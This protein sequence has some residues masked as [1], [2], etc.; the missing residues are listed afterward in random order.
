MTS[1]EKSSFSAEAIIVLSLFY[2]FMHIHEDIIITN[3]CTSVGVFL[4]PTLAA[5]SCVHLFVC[6]CAAVMLTVFLVHQD[7]KRVHLIVLECQP[8][9]L[10]CVFICEFSVHEA[11]RR[12]QIQTFHI[13][14]WVWHF[15][16]NSFN[17]IL[18]MLVCL[19]FNAYIF[20]AVSKNWSSIKMHY[21]SNLWMN[22]NKVA[23]QCHR[24]TISG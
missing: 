7:L 19:H 13:K 10:A 4:L 18:G 8:N 5:R 14:I 3:L 24:R 16:E 20:K 9:F 22:A 12:K 1:E 6:V 2:T 21:A 15:T 23:L 11:E 17:A